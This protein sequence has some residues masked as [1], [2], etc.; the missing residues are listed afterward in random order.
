MLESFRNNWDIYKTLLELI[1]VSFIDHQHDFG[2]G[3][4][5]LGI[6]IENGFC[7]KM[8]TLKEKECRAQWKKEL[9]EKL[10]QSHI[11]IE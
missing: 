5:I 8:A 4:S 3:V 9:K 11:A 2:C 10:Y 7:L 1:H 6:K